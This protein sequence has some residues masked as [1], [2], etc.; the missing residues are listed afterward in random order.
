MHPTQSQLFADHYNLLGLMRC[1]E[2]EIACYEASQP[3]GAHL[4]VI[5]DIFDYIQFYPE[6]YHHPLE[7]ALFERLLIK[8]VKNSDQIWAIKS[9]HKTL[10][11][12]TRRASQLFT[13]V[14]NDSVVPVAELVRVTREFLARQI[15]HIDRENRIVY[16]LL[17]KY[18]TLEEWDEITAQVA[19]RKDPLFRQAVMDEYRNLYDAILQ[20]ESALLLGP[21]ARGIKKPAAAV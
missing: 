6:R 11:A 14:A 3:W 2:A 13:S 8:Q 17:E 16:P 19:Q 18:I 10:E 21:T 15:D 9:E 20:A 1:L 12:L 4:S 7:D 5:L